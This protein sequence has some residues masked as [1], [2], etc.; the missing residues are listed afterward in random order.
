M[1]LRPI[2][3]LDPIEDI[4]DDVA[5][6]YSG[7]DAIDDQSIFNNNLP[8]AEPSPTA[9][10]TFDLDTNETETI[11]Y[12]HETFYYEHKRV[13]EV[14]LL[15][16]PL[17]ETVHADR[18]HLT[19][20]EN[21]SDEKTHR[22]LITCLNNKFSQIMMWHQPHHLPKRLNR[23]HEIILPDIA[24]AR[25]LCLKRLITSLFMNCKR[26]PHF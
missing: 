17:R 4:H 22:H 25:H 11:N 20:T 14:P 10:N 19:E 5:R 13:H 2:V 24:F 3:P 1:R 9:E 18:T 23:S 16:N 12:E 21:Q 6:H 7:P 15:Y 26:S 8:A